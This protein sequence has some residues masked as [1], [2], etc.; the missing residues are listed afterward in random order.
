MIHRSFILAALAGAALVPVAA[1]G[2]GAASKFEFVSQSVMVMKGIPARRAAEP[3]AAKVAPAEAAAARSDKVL[4]PMLSAEERRLLRYGLAEENKRKLAEAERKLLNEGTV[5]LSDFTPEAEPEPKLEPA[6]EP[7][8][9]DASN[10]TVRVEAPSNTAPMPT[11]WEATAEQK[12]DKAA[13]Q[14]HQR[15]QFEAEAPQPSQRETREAVREREQSRRTPPR[16]VAPESR[17][18]PLSLDG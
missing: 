12:P 17:D 15:R 16:E 18:D 9:F 7:A 8:R 3:V 2:A 5:K 13:M 6:A 1:T 11:R 10:T 14:A 4:V